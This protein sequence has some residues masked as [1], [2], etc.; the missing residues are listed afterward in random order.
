MEFGLGEAIPLYAGGLGVLAGDYLKT[1]SDLNVPM[2]GIGLLY[3]E[4]YFR[5]TIDSSNWPD[6][7]VS[8]QRSLI[9]FLSSLPGILQ[10]PGWW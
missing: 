10:E 5:Q 7:N 3:Q 8:Q 6:R 9:S 1:A 4:G 2:I